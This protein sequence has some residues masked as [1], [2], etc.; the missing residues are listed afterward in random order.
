M[1]SS[2][3]Y[4]VGAAEVTRIS[5]LE[6]RD[7]TPEK[8]YPGAWTPETLSSHPEWFPPWTMDEER[9]HLLMS[10]HSWLIRERGRTTLV[11]TG[12]GNDKERP[13]SKYFDRLSTS[14]LSN[15]AAAAVRP[16][17]VDFI[18]TTHVHVDHVGWNTRLEDGVWVPTFPNARYIFSGEEHAFFTD[19]AN[20]TE[21]NRTS[22]ATQKDS[23]DPIIKA[24]LADRIN[25]D[26]AAPIP[27]FR[28]EGTPGHSPYHASI[29]FESE[30]RTAFF[31]GDVM[32]H[33]IQ[34]HRP[35]WN[36]MFDADGEAAKRSRAWALSFAVEREAQV[37]SSHFPGS[38][39][40]YVRAETSGFGWESLD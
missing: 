11:D 25:I 21:R 6:L 5:D 39:T 10:V 19:K 24:G 32:H 7:F 31:S 36:A 4:R 1:T 30:G 18:L 26:G 16:E 34:V 2:P 3:T 23:V 27:G 15:L 12:A 38:S 28:F 14:Y 22:F 29:I 20:L 37:F 40:G 9:K 8:L 33:P 13:D 17:D 35:D